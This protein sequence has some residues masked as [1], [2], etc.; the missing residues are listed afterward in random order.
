MRDSAIWFYGRAAALVWV[1]MAASVAQA[2][3]APA[4]PDRFTTTTASMTP[5]DVALRID[6]REWSDDE[7]RAAVV[8]NDAAAATSITEAVS[9]LDKLASKGIIPK[10]RASRVKGRLAAAAHAAKNA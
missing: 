8:A 3:S 4:M 9:A 10:K 7:A 1:V 2:H 5:A 6:V